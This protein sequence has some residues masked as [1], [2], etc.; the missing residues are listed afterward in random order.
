[1]RYGIRSITMD[2]IATQLGIS[3]KTIYQFFTDKDDLVYAVIEAEVHKNESECIE[4]CIRSI[5]RQDYPGLEVVAVNDRSTDDTGTILNRL[6]D[7]FGDRMRVIHVTTH[8][9][10]L[11]AI[12]T[13]EAGLVERVIARGRDVL[14]KAALPRQKIGVC[15]I[16]PHAG[17]HGLFGYGEEEAKIV[18]SGV[19]EVARLQ[20]QEGYVYLKP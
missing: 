19:A 5:F 1:M 13:I 16:N 6:A 7:E 11:D 3:K 17:E 15:A 14:V 12:A 10:L 2:E 20:A 18:P 9:G 4:T 8:I